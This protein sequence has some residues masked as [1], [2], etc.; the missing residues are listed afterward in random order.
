M[1]SSWP[2][3]FPPRCQDSSGKALHDEGNGS[4]VWPVQT[5]KHITKCCLEGIHVGVDTY[6]YNSQNRYVVM[7]DD[8]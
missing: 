5:L 4:A 2:G 6:P 3:V 1:C 8:V 7:Y